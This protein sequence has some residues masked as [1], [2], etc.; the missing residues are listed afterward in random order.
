DRPAWEVLHG[1]RRQAREVLDDRQ[2][3]VQLQ[4]PEAG[5]QVDAV[6]AAGAEAVAIVDLTAPED[7][8]V[9]GADTADRGAGPRHLF[10]ELAEAGVRGGDRPEQVRDHIRVHGE[11]VDDPAGEERP[12]VDAARG[13]VVQPPDG[14]QASALAEG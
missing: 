9:L 11:A 4:I 8:A 5:E 2:P 14:A 12:R 6:V 10:A 13:A 7:A 3:L 1:Q